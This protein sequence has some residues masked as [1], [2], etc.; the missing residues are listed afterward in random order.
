MLNIKLCVSAYAGLDIIEDTIERLKKYPEPG[1]TF[2]DSVAVGSTIDRNRNLCITRE[3]GKYRPRISTVWDYYVF[4]DTDMHTQPH[5]VYNMI[6][7]IR[8][9][10]HIKILCYPYLKNSIGDK[11]Y[12]VSIDGER[13]VSPERLKELN[14]ILPVNFSAMGCSIIEAEVFEYMDFPYFQL[15]YD[16]NLQYQGEDRYFQKKALELGHKTYVDFNYTV[17]HELRK[18]HKKRKKP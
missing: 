10:S 4:L 18:P 5:H 11:K 12:N 6:D 13:L 17:Q 16:E 3:E 15:G 2:H 1:F 8:Y 7:S 9:T 14:G